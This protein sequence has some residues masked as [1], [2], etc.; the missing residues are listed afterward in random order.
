MARAVA[1]FLDHLEHE[2]R[3]SPRTL[4]AY[5]SDLGQ[6]LQELDSGGFSGGPAE[7]EVERLRAY[8]ARIHPATEPR[9]RARKLSAL[10][11]FY[12]FLVRQKEVPT[13]VGEALSSPKFPAPLPRALGVDDVF[14]LLDAEGSGSDPALVARDRALLELLYGAGVRAAELVGLDLDRLDLERGTVRVLGKGSKERVVPFGDKARSALRAWLELRPAVL[15][16]GPAAEPAAVFLNARGGRLTTRSLA[17][18]LDHRAAEV[19]LE[20]RVTPHMLRHSFATH[21]LTN[22]ADL[23]AIQTM[24]GHASL[25]TTQRYTA[26]SIEHLRDVYDSAHPLG[27]APPDRPAR[28]MGPGP[29]RR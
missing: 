3:V 4:R 28:G 29:D 5:R 12:R 26:V 9:T 17:R 16:R 18:R 19:A 13:N 11:S 14:R 23:R 22:G 24:L 6:L 21:L 7:V 20:R 8:F 15:L 10:R 2:R 25:G 27:D 1:R